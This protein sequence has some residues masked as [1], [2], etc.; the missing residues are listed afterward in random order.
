MSVTM[1]TRRAGSCQQ[2]TVASREKRC[3]LGSARRRLAWSELATRSQWRGRIEELALEAALELLMLSLASVLGG[4]ALARNVDP[5][6]GRR[7]YDAHINVTGSSV[8]GCPLPASR[9]GTFCDELLAARQ[10]VGRN[11]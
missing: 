10:P 3:R 9:R 6:S 5:H 8:T 1:R 11:S 7:G 4:V 2:L